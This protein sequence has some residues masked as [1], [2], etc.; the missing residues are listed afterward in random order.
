[1]GVLFL[2]GGPDEKPEDE[3]GWPIRRVCVWG[4]FPGVPLAG[5]SSMNHSNNLHFIY[6]YCVSPLT[7][8]FLAVAVVPCLVSTGGFVRTHDPFFPPISAATSF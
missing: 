8:S 7:L 6:A 1:V 4:L 3:F 5:F 2:A